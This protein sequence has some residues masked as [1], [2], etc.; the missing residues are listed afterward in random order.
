MKTGWLQDTKWYYL[1]DDGSMAINKV[2]PDGT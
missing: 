1:Q 2:S